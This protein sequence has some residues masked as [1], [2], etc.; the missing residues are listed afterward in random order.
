MPLFPLKSLFV[1]LVKP[2]FA[3]PS[4]NTFGPSQ[5]QT[6]GGLEPLKCSSACASLFPRSFRTSQ[7]KFMQCIQAWQRQSVKCA[8]KCLS[9][10][11]DL[12]LF[13]LLHLALCQLFGWR[14]RSSSYLQKT[15]TH[16]NSQK[17]AH[18]WHAALEVQISQ[19]SGPTRSLLGI[20]VTGCGCDLWRKNTSDIWQEHTTNNRTKASVI[21]I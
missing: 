6:R 10:Q 18:H 8:P 20:W 3:C 2:A 14:R 1:A 15:K 7:T 4:I 16:Q 11:C 9:N 12:H 21:Y 5:K 13:S 19:V 17:S